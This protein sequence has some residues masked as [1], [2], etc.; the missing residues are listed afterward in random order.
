MQTPNADFKYRHLHHEELQEGSKA[1]DTISV[2]KSIFPW[3][4]NVAVAIPVP[5]FTHMDTH[6]V[7]YDGDSVQDNYMSGQG[8]NQDARTVTTAAKTSTTI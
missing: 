2:D 3:L 4:D 6:L 8:T 5:Q 7:H 1:R